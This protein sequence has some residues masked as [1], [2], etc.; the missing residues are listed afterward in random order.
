MRILLDTNVLCR[1]ADRGHP[2]HSVAEDAIAK[3]RSEGHELCLVP[4]VLYEYWVVV[5]RPAADNG[6]GMDV[7]AADQAANLWLELF[8][9]LRDERGVF[10]EW[11]SLLRQ[12][13]V[14]GKAAHDARLVAAMKRHGLSRLL[15]FNVADFARYNGIEVINANLV[16]SGR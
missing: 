15:T 6:L 12:Y 5:T 7:G 16:A 8:T 4:Q 9:L 11:R 14:R 1:L 3:L 13:G 2:L 10:D